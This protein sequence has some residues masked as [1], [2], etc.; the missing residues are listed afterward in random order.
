MAL[1]DPS[2]PFQGTNRP[3][4]Q[5]LIN[6]T[7]A[8][9]LITASI[10]SNNHYNA[11]RFSAQLALYAD[12]TFTLAWW[13]GSDPSPNAD[14]TLA[15]TP[16]IQIEF[17]IGF[18]APG[19]AES[20]V[21]WQTP[22]FFVGAVDTLD[23][24][25]DAAR[26]NI[27]GR[28]FTSRLIETKT[29]ATY[30]N[31]TASEVVQAIAATHGSPWTADVTAT[32]TPVGKYYQL[33][34]DRLTLG[35]FSRQ[36]TEWDLL[37]N[38]A[39]EEGYDLWVSGTTIHFHPAQDPDTSNPWLINYTLPTRQNPVPQSNV[40]QLRLSRSLYLARDITVTVKSWNSKQKKA[41][42]R[43][44]RSSRQGGGSKS[45]QV[46]NYVIIRPNLTQDQADKIGTSYLESLSQHER[47][48]TFRM[49][50]DSTTTARTIFKIQGTSSGFDQAYFVDTIERRIS[51]SEGF[52][53]TVSLKNHD[54]RSQS[55]TN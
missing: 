9:G 26:I 41:F 37:T 45:G 52:V 29:Q 10:T 32:T 39:Q 43:I 51:M 42:Q 8:T 11:D 18:V 25:M 40:S 27:D 53:Q 24:D 34:H 21:V 44:I 16:N 49:I 3:R 20:A 28:D 12:P 4:L 46:Q 31:Q 5:A 55:V 2:Q 50:G 14:G 23:I 6:G 38:L 17:Q 19:Q 47:R 1:N 48:A 22:S 36:T 30:S 54:P 13:A 33:E 35:S 15:P 7:V